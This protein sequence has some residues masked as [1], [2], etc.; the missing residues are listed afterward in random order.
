MTARR[1]PQYGPPQLC[2]VVCFGPVVGI[3]KVAFHV[4]RTALAQSVACR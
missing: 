2:G 4:L 3:T 1:V